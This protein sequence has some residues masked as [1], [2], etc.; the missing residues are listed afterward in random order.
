MR[1]KKEELRVRCR[2]FHL[3]GKKQRVAIV[4][5]DDS[6]GGQVLV[7]DCVEDS[8]TVDATTAEVN[9]G[10]RAGIWSDGGAASRKFSGTTGPGANSGGGASV[11]SLHSCATWSGNLKI[12]ANGKAGRADLPSTGG[13][14][15][16]MGRFCPYAVLLSMSRATRFPSRHNGFILS[17]N[18]AICFSRIDEDSTVVR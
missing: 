7:P 9:A 6:Y 18:V 3:T 5:G 17:R 13:S 10:L 1:G 15:A 14:D 8:S 12:L 11:A 16:I 2:S 4:G